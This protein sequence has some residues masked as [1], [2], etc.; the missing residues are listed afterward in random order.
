M[1]GKDTAD[2]F[3]EI[4]S[5]PSASPILFKRFIKNPPYFGLFTVNNVS[6]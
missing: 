1:L 5:K 6:N 2:T 4:T 3:D